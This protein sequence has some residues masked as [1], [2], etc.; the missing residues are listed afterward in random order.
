MILNENV[1]I[2]DYY[3]IFIYLLFRW[4]MIN[5]CNAILLDICFLQL[6]F[7]SIKCF[8][9]HEVLR[10]LILSNLPSLLYV[11]LFVTNDIITV[12]L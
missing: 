11:I 4:W 9:A 12:I 5:F 1:N 7:I 8:I 6:L 3:Y 2:Y 10:T